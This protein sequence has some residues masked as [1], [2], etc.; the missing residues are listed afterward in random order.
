MLALILESLCFFPSLAER[1]LRS[2]CDSVSTCCA[3]SGHWEQKWAAG[4]PHPAA[5]PFTPFFT[6]NLY[7]PL[8]VRPSHCSHEFYTRVTDWAQ[9]IHVA[10]LMGIQSQTVSSLIKESSTRLDVN[11][12]N[13]NF[14]VLLTLTCSWRVSQ[15]N[16]NW[17]VYNVKSASTLQHCTC[18][19]TNSLD[20]HLQQCHV[21]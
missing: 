20:K 17:N 19:E 2:G 21:L 7:Q 6:L 16:K 9:D 1:S 8:Y 18:Y 14:K 15:M 3:R 12:V 13:I 10:L 5:L 11:T 4:A